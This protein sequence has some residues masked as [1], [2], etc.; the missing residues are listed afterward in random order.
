MASWTVFEEQAVWISPRATSFTVVCDACARSLATEGYGAAIVHGT[1]EL[2]RLRGWVT[3][4][5]GHQLRVERDG[6]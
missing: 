4:A 2:D 5:G 1:L 6:R 3:C